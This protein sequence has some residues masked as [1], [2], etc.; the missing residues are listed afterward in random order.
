MY[1]DGVVEIV[2]NGIVNYIGF[3]DVVIEMEVNWIVIEVESLFCMKDFYVVEFGCYWIFIFF[4]CMD[5]DLDIKFIVVN[6]VIKFFLKVCLSWELFRFKVGWI[7]FNYFCLLRMFWVLY[8]N[9]F[10]EEIDFCLCFYEMYFVKCL[11][12][13]DVFIFKCWC[14]VECFVFVVDFSDSKFFKFVLWFFCWS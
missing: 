11:S 6:F 8:L 3:F 5:Y 12:D 4:G 10:G 7:S 1:G 2:M 9:V 14:N 13:W